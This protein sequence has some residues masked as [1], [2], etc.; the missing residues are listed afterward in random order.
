MVEEEDDDD[1]TAGALFR[2][3]LAAGLDPS[4]PMGISIR[5]C[6]RDRRREDDDVLVVVVEEAIASDSTNSSGI[7][8]V[9]AIIRFFLLYS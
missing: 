4:P 8:S 1:F 6:S 2:I 7:P 5:S 9:F 3:T